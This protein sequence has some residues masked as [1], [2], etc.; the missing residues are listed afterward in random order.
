MS[1]LRNAVKRIT[2]KERN[3]PRHRSHLGLLEKKKDYTI[4]AKNYHKKQDQRRILLQK[5]AQRNPDEFYFG[6]HNAQIDKDGSHR[7]TLERRNEALKDSIGPDAVRIMKDQ[8]LSYVRMIREIDRKKVRKLQS[9]LH[10]VGADDIKEDTGKR[11]HLIFVD[12]R[13]PPGVAKDGF[14]L[15]AH[16]QTPPELVG[17]AFNRPRIETLRKKKG[18]GDDDEDKDGDDEIVTM[19]QQP[20]LATEKK[21]RRKRMER[22]E[23][24]VE[25]TAKERANA[26]KELEAR[27]ERIKTLEITEAHLVTE[28]LLRGKGAKRKI[29]DSEDGRPAVYKWKRK[30]SK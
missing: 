23:K 5:A 1:S 21:Q 7:M 30:R 24:L 26:Y 11:T 3:Q 2:H 29:K 10:F 27:K 4:R 8:D 16:F 25:A 14:D 6:M 17:R 13:P 15:A 12:E 19:K 9:G 20:R 28:K 18:M 22:D